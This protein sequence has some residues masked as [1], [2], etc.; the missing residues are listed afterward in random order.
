MVLEKKTL[1]IKKASPA[2]T[3]KSKPGVKAKVDTSKPPATKVAAA[4]IR[5]P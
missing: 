4:M 1:S 2:T 3:P 5:I